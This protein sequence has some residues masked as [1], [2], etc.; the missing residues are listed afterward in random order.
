MP[1]QGQE[2]RG[3]GG[4]V[5]EGETNSSLSS[6]PAYYHESDRLALRLAGKV[7]GWVGWLPA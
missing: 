3:G 7:D 5:V 4:V 1:G 2:G 6:I